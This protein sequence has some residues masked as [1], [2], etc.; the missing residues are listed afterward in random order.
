M[1]VHSDHLTGRGFVD[2]S[3]RVAALR[4]AFTVTV[5]YLDKILDKILGS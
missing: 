1:Y 4:Q 3:Y 2:L 5:Y